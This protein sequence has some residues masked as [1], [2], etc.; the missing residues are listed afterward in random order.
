MVIVPFK[1][2]NAKSRLAALLSEEERDEFARRMLRDVTSSLR[3]S[4]VDGFMMLSEDGLNESINGILSCRNEETLIVMPDLPLITAENID[5]IVAHEEEIVIAPGRR[6]GTNVL[7]IRSPRRFHV[8]YHG[9]SFLDHLKIARENGLSTGIYDSFLAST[10]I[11][12]VDDLIDL[13]T[14]GN[15]YA[16]QYLSEIGILLRVEGE[17]VR[18]DRER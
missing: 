12:E 18:V 16:A 8:D 15:G 3:D 17:R 13:L 5:E 14:H 1:E 10:D 7:F 4:V 11:D 6:G 2:R 9:L